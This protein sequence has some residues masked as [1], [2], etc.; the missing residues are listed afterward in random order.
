VITLVLGGARSGKSGLAERLAADL[1]PPVTYVATLHVGDDPD[2]AARVERHRARRP[3]A[4][5]TVQAGTA[6]PELLRTL[7][8]SVLVDSLGPWVSASDAMQVDVVALC[9]ALV[10]REG[11]SV[12]VSDEVGL[13]VHPSTEN[14]RRFR[15]ALGVLNQAVAA[16]ADEVL[17]VVAGCTLRLDRPQDR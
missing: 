6:L 11:D 5:R 13:S 17:L 16:S 7:T 4:W 15:D 14:G 8:G 10:Q 9:S 3:P 1:A 12:V 2:L